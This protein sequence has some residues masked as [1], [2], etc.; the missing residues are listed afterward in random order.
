MGSFKMTFVLVIGECGCGHHHDHEHG[1]HHSHNSM[2][3]IAHIVRDHLD[4][5]EKVK[6]DVLAVYGRIA[7]AEA[8]VH[9]VPVSDIHFHE[10]GTMDAVADVTAVCLLMCYS[11]QI[12]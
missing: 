11:N 6:E 10:V 8:H 9:G 4:L 3:G 5:P 2:A 1:H 7:E 12:A